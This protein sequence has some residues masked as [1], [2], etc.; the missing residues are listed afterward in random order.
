MDGI[1]LKYVIEMES[2]E[3]MYIPGFIKIGSSVLKL[4]WG[5]KQARKRTDSMVVSEAYFLFS[6]FPSFLKEI[7]SYF[8]MKLFIHSI[9]QNIPIYA[10]YSFICY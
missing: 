10:G 3:L 8:Y 4:T 7:F 1:L 5:D 2:V 9:H 6:I